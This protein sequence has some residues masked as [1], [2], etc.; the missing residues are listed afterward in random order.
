MPKKPLIVY[1]SFYGNTDVVAKEIQKQIN[2]DVIRI[3][4]VKS[5]KKGAMIG[6]AFASLLGF[7]S[8]IKP[9]DFTMKHHDVVFLGLQVWA[10]HTTPA[11]NRFLSKA[12]F[13]NKQVYLFITNAEQTK[14][15]NVIN[16]VTKRIKKKGGTVMDV[17]AHRSPWLPN[18]DKVISAAEVEK[19]IRLWLS[20]IGLID[21]EQSA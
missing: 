2:S 14:P 3:E 19:P 15:E 6:P 16:S 5:R 7:K 18:D 1:Y 9:L 4:E 11:I 8:A 13:Q 17:F 12:S 10:R 20:Q 21:D